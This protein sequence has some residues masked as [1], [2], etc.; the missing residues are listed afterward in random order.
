MQIC[1]AAGRSLFLTEGTTEN[2]V[3]QSCARVMQSRAGVCVCCN[4]PAH[5]QHLP[6]PETGLARS[7]GLGEEG[8]PQ[9]GSLFFFFFPHKHHLKSTETGSPSLTD[10]VDTMRDFSLG[11]LRSPSAY[12][13]RVQAALRNAFV[14]GL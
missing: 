11:K 4:Q 3:M 8:S 5:A 2:R 7:G 14:L 6:L 1:G 9:N 13:L 10:A 12:S